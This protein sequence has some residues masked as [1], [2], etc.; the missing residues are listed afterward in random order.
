MVEGGL[1]DFETRHGTLSVNL[2]SKGLRF[3][4]LSSGDTRI[5]TINANDGL[6]QNFISKAGNDVE[7][8]IDDY[9]EY[10]VERFNKA[11]TEKFAEEDEGFVPVEELLKQLLERLEWNGEGFEIKGHP[12]VNRG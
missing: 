9:G 6:V 2:E 4:V 3:I 12:E 10:L 5:V 7:K 8:G 1:M 11:V